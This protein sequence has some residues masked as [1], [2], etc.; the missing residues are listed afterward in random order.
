MGKYDDQ[1]EERSPSNT[2]N[3]GSNVSG[4]PAADGRAEDFFSQGS[5]WSCSQTTQTKSYFDTVDPRNGSNQ[6]ILIGEL[7]HQVKHL[8]C[9]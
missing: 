6:T 7:T 1:S 8:D 4:G 3:T 2:A 9:D 5:L